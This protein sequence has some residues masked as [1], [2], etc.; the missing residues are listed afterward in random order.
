MGLSNPK[1]PNLALFCNL[2]ASSPRPALTLRACA[3]ESLTE[4]HHPAISRVAAGDW[5]CCHYQRRSLLYKYWMVDAFT[6]NPK[7]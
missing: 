6:L 3:L 4:R 2:P 7:A 1:T 5:P